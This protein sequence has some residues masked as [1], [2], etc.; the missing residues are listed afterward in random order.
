M[1][2]WV[3]LG[4]MGES[5][6]RKVAADDIYPFPTAKFNQHWQHHLVAGIV[7]AV[8][9]VMAKKSTS[10]VALAV[11]AVAASAG[12]RLLDVHLKKLGPMVLMCRGT[13]LVLL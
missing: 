13:M 3:K 1:V 10:A 11:G 5:C 2:V 8:A 6:T 4:A 7:M 9:V 12:R